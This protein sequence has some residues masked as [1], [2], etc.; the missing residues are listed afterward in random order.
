MY[1]KGFHAVTTHR[2]AHELWLQG[3][4]DFAFFLQ[5]LESQV[6]G[7]D[8]HPAARFGKGIM[9]DHAT[10][11]VVGETA[12]IGDNWLVPAWC[13]AGPAAAR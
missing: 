4:R 13:D 8:I 9:L 10:G 11:F 7:V 6:F 2:F 5:S 12:V 1:F 3:N